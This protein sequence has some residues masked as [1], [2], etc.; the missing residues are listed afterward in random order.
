MHRN[1]I[2]RK[3]I[4][5]FNFQKAIMQVLLQAL[6][7]SA[8]FILNST[9]LILQILLCVFHDHYVYAYHEVGLF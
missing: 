2:Q 4:N 8:I 7:K 6:S 1:C 3:T 5:R 9:G